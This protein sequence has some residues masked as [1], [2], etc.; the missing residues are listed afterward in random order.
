M[1]M[2]FGSHWVGRDRTESAAQKPARLG[3][4]RG[5]VAVAA[6]A[7]AAFAVTAAPAGAQT[8]EQ[9]L[10]LAYQ[11]NPDIAAQ[12]ASLRGTNEQV[13]QALGGW[14]PTVTA[15]ASYQRQWR[16]D[17]FLE[18]SP[19]TGNVDSRVVAT[20]PASIGITLNQS[21]YDGGQTAAS[22][23]QAEL[24]IQA[25]RAAL[26]VV[27][28]TVLLQTVGGY[29]GVVLNQALLELNL[30]NEEVLSRQL[31]ATRDRFEVGEIT[32]TDVSQA[33]S[34][35]AQAQADRIS[36]AG[37]LRQARATFERLVG[38][39]P[40]QVLFP[41][42]IDGLLPTTLDDAITMA[43]RGNPDVINAE[44]AK[45]AA[46]AGVDVQFAGLLPQL[47]F[48]AQIQQ[49][50]PD[51]TNIRDQQ[52]ASVGITLSFPLYQSGVVSSRVREARY[53][54]GQR[55]I[56]VDVARRDAVETAITAW[57]QLQASRAA[58][59]ALEVQVQAAEVALDGVRQEALVG[60]RTTLDVL[61][62]EQEVLSSRVS[63]VSAQVEEV[64]AAFELLAAVG[65]LSAAN[66]GLPV[67]LYNA[68][69][70]YER[71]RQRLWGTRIE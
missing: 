10:A 19:Q 17:N 64:N 4:R 3:P 71:T 40:S 38:V 6:I 46:D 39:V 32:R 22:V 43:E 41:P 44:F 67:A 35:L 27:E 68:D 70:D 7:L 11:S 9:A 31:Q 12:R 59:R 62:A 33:E 53:L 45:L 28:Q 26:D 47:D 42:R 66:L 69:A 60:S 15:E 18:P 63:L 49:T 24:T 16:Q 14:R 8:L 54:A 48:T 1:T 2:R 21:L 65:G 20:N 51:T 58:I 57:E 5:G 61:D 34:R 37:D 29:M 56:E 50:W 13:A 52:S 25:A 36:A 23:E 30:N 55:R